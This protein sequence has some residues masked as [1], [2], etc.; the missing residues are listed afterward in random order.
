MFRYL[1]Q[2]C[3]INCEKMRVHSTTQALPTH[4]CPLKLCVRAREGRVRKATESPSVTLKELQ[5]SVTETGVQ[6]HQELCIQ[7]ACFG[8]WL[9]RSHYWRKKKP[10]IKARLK[11]ASYSAKR[12]CGQMRKIKLV[13]G[14]YSTL[15]ILHK[16]HPSS[17]V[18]GW[19]HLCYGDALPH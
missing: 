3:Q 14:S 9:K 13:Y 11:F 5:S 15:P 18:W 16:H 4:G 7:L 2:H 19:Q 8:G 10:H 6:M 1:C 17:E 12:F